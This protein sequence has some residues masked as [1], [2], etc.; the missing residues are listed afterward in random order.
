MAS[1][2][3]EGDIENEKRIA[4]LDNKK[5]NKYDK[6]GWYDF[7]KTDLHSWARK[8]EQGISVGTRFKPKGWRASFN[9]GISRVATNI[10]QQRLENYDYVTKEK[11]DN[12]IKLKLEFENEE[13]AKS[14]E[15]SSIRY[16]IKPTR[17]N[18]EDTRLFNR[19]Q[20]GN[21]TSDELHK[22]TESSGTQLQNNRGESENKSKGI[23]TEGNNNKGLK[24]YKNLKAKNEV[25]FEKTEK[26]KDTEKNLVRIHIKI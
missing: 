9:E 15:R 24:F 21:G 14:N 20:N 13:I 6:Q 12:G 8:T 19:E 23:S 25:G 3:I 17:E 4:K 16:A 10:D 1:K 11:I 22:K 26:L 18:N 2:N 5:E 7:E